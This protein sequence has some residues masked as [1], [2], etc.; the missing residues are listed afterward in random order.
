MK[1]DSN[2]AKRIKEIE[3]E[4][5]HDVKAIEY[6][7]HSKIKKQLHPW[8]HFC[9]TSEDVNNLAYSLMWKDALEDLYLPQLISI[10]KQLKKFTE[11]TL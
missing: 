5:N 7:L 8:I 10:Q 9:L 6:F 2:D 11:Y 4:T 3:K 1:F